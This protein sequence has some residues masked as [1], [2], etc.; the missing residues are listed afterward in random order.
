MPR[1]TT[2]KKAQKSQGTCEKCGNKIEVGSSY[3]WW[4][5]R[6][7]GRHVRCSDSKCAPRPSDLTQS[8]FYSTL[9]D[10]KDQLGTAL[11]D[12]R[13]GG[14]PSDLSSTLT[15]IAGELRTLGE[16]CQEKLDNMPEGLQQG[17]TGQLLQTRA[18]E[19]D[20]KAD[21]LE[22]AA[23]TLDSYEEP[24]DED[25]KEAARDDAVAEA[26]IDLSID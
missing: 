6:H 18:E 2:V 23:S 13:A 5:F 7:G 1:V 20:G 22:S 21:E 24:E 12:F 4:K 11:D 25:D 14:D 9:Y 17:D 3:R 16:E 19:C 15:D 10:L 8:E 26:D